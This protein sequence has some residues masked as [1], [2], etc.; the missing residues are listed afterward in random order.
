MLNWLKP[1]TNYLVVE[2]ERPRPLTDLKK[3][4]DGEAAVASL[5]GHPGFEYLL[6]KFRVQKALLERSLRS[7]LHQDLNSVLRLQA[8]VFWSGWLEEQLTQAKNRQ[9][10]TAQTPAA[11]ELKLFNEIQAA[12]TKVG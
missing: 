3:M 2:V 5:Q 9:D 6:A 11:E 7:E 4:K 12:L 8:G 1:K 10:R